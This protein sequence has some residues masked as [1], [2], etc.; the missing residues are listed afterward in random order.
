MLV[1]HSLGGLYAQLYARSYPDEVSGLVLVD[2]V[3]PRIKD[4][5]NPAVSPWWLRAGAY[6]GSS[7]TSYEEIRGIEDTARRITALPPYP[8][9][10]VLV[11]RAT[12]PMI[13]DKYEPKDYMATLFPSGRVAMVEGGHDIPIDNPDVVIAAIRAAVIYHAAAP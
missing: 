9:K 4:I 7:H 3:F 1:G 5:L 13:D 8:G 11:L 6:I 10:N 12:R 2:S